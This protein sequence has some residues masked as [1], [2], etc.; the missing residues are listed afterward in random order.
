[1]RSR[2]YTG[3]L[4]NMSDSATSDRSEELSDGRYMYCLV[5]TVESDGP[6][7]AV[8]GIDDSSLSLI[9]HGGITAVTHQCERL[10]DSE[11][12]DQVRQWLVAHQRV[13]DAAGSTFGTP[14]PF[15]FDVI[16]RGGEEGVR[17]W[18]ADNEERIREALDQLGGLWEYRAHVTWDRSAV[19]SIV[20]KEDDRLAEIEA[21]RDESGKGTQFLLDKQYDQR[22]TDVL[23]TRKSELRDRLQANLDDI[24]R[25]VKRHGATPSVQA[26]GGLDDENKEWVAR[27]ALLASDADEASIGAELDTVASEPG[28]T[29]EFTGPWPPYSFAPEFTE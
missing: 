6:E 14:L 9:T 25:N 17:Q 21:Q 5:D 4:M 22:L 7:L 26:I 2:N 12:A 8:N 18:I 28:V 11:D 16:L 15:Q 19:E 27:V 3:R 20:S 10:Y 29:V 13:I 23:H 24:A 1:M